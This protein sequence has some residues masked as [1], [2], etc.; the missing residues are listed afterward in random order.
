[1]VGG[2]EDAIGLETAALIGAAGKGRKKASEFGR[3][4]GKEESIYMCEEIVEI[5]R[6]SSMRARNEREKIRVK[7]KR[8]IGRHGEKRRIEGG[9]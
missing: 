1:M 4:V 5:P 3:R 8:I 2:R 7:R 6:F 9:K